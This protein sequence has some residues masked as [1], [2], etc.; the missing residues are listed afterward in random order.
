MSFA[1]G[2]RAI[3]AVHRYLLNGVLIESRLEL[4]TIAPAPSAA[5]ATT[6]VRVERGDGPTD[7]WRE[8]YGAAG[9][10]DP[11]LAVDA[12]A[13]GYRLRLRDTCDFFVDAAGS[14]VRCAPRPEVP[15][16]VVEQLLV[17]VVIPRV[18]Q[19]H[20][21]PWLHASAVAL[22]RGGV[23]LLGS[24]GA[25]K[26]TLCAALT[27]RRGAVLCDDSL[28][29]EVRGDDVLA[30]PGYPSL[31]IWPDSAAQLVGAE[32]PCASPRT[33]KRRLERMLAVGPVPMRLALLLAP[34][35]PAPSIEPLA[36]AAAFAELA[37][38]L[39]RLDPAAPALLREEFEWL[40]AVC[41]RLPVARLRFA[42]RFSELRATVDA[43]VRHLTP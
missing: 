37:G 17:D 15:W 13:S 40:G 2:R 3:D 21:P 29:L 27:E 22:E 33:D 19:L 5:G 43:I 7:G 25:G 11:F 28:A 34:G 8:L 10:E 18:A 23:A 31:R 14:V 41:A 6:V 16:G 24:A 9:S 1:P 35:E 38:C 12:G 39:H 42:H 26:S 20:G 4:P 30:A 36:P 32:L